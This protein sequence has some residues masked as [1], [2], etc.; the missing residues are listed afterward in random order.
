MQGKTVLSAREGGSR[1]PNLGLSERESK[2]RP[3]GWGLKKNKWTLPI[4]L[5][6][7]FF[8]VLSGAIGSHYIFAGTPPIGSGHVDDVIS[9]TPI[10]GGPNEVWLCSSGRVTVKEVQYKDQ[11]GN[12]VDVPN[13][14]VTPN[15][16]NYNLEI[17]IYPSLPVG[18]EIRVKYEYY[19]LPKPNVSLIC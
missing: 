11:N 14:D 4:V 6:S 10:Q 7:T 16:N 5:L 13:Y 17:E 12:W 9:I 3:V 19:T 8:L 18:T 15:S 1:G 2:G